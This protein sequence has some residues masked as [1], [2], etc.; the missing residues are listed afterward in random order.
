[1]GN[2]VSLG[3]KS[4]VLQGFTAQTTE[5]VRVTSKSIIGEYLAK[6]PREITIDKLLIRQSGSVGFSETAGSILETPIAEVM[7][8]LCQNRELMKVM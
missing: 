8:R 3:Y 6:V 2:P 7:V 4:H 5:M 1:V